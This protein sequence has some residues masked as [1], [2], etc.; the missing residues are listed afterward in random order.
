MEIGILIPICKNG[1]SDMDCYSK[2]YQMEELKGVK[3]GKIL[4]DFIWRLDIK[5]T[6]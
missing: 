2:P 1:A 5:L 4:R 3:I 6:L